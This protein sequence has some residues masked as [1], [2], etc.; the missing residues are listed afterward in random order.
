MENLEKQ[1]RAMVKSMEDFTLHNCWG[2]RPTNTKDPT[3]G[4]GSLLIFIFALHE[5]GIVFGGNLEKKKFL[6]LY[7]LYYKY[8]YY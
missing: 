7:F 1:F 5:K 6:G 4:P 2:Q 3:K 8:F